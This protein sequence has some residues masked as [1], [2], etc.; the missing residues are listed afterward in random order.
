MRTNAAALVVLAVLAGCSDAP[1]KDVPQ[2]GAAGPPPNPLITDEP[3]ATPAE[4]SPVPSSARVIIEEYV[5]GSLDPR[6]TALAMERILADTKERPLDAGPGWQVSMRRALTHAL[7]TTPRELK[8]ELRRYQDERSRFETAH[9]ASE[10]KAN[11]F[12]SVIALADRYPNAAFALGLW[13]RLA[14]ER[15]TAPREIVDT[16]KEPSV[17]EE[18]VRLEGIT[19]R[20][21][22]ADALVAQDADGLTVWEHRARGSAADAPVLHVLGTFAD[23]VVV[24]EHGKAGAEVEA[25]DI[26]TGNPVARI[27]APNITGA[28]SAVLLGPDVVLAVRGRV[29]LADLVRG[30]VGW[31][32]SH[33]YGPALSVTDDRIV[34]DPSGVGLD[35]TTG[36]LVEGAAGKPRRQG[37]VEVR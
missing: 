24:L 6:A 29:V 27:A 20:A 33:P 11:R 13:N 10:I 12:K 9:V 7:V 4:A 23:K 17:P 3:R 5:R 25:I 2:P 32:R 16:A 30:V 22:G 37:A 21:N 1:R 34:L 35:L 31:E 36:R 15:A 14:K 18:G 19:V 28:P 8:S 26:G